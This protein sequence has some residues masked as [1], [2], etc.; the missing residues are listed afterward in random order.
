MLYLGGGFGGS[1]DV[2]CER[3][4]GFDLHHS[5]ESDGETCASQD[6]H[7]SPED[8]REKLACIVDDNLIIEK[9][10]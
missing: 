5:H 4:R 2:V 8:W 3:R 10:N 9:G 1:G 6:S 7:R